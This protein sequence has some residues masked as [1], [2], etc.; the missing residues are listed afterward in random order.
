M[1]TKLIAGLCSA[2]LA[3]ACFSM[4]AFADEEFTT[5]EPTA[6][7][8]KLLG[9]TYYN[10]ES[11]WFS[12]TNSGVEYQFT[13]TATK[14]TVSGDANAVSATD[15][16]R[17]AVFA[18]G[19]RV[20]DTMLTYNPQTLTVN[21]EAGTHTIKLL[22]ISESA[23]G[24]IF[25]DDISVNGE[26]AITPTAAKKHSIE[27]IGDSITCGYGIDSKNENEHFSTFTEDGSRTY[28]YKAAQKLDAD[29]S[30]VSYSGFGVLSGYT[31]NGQINTTGLVSKYY[32][33]VGF[34]WGWANGH[35]ISEND[36]DFSAKPNDLVVVN[37]GTNDASYTK[38]NAEKIAD[39]TDAYVDF[40]KL[41]REKNP[42]SEI[43]CTLGIMGQDLYNA[44]EEAVNKYSEET[45]DIKVN[46][47]KFD[48]QDTADGLGGDWHPSEKTHEK[49]ANKLIDEINKLY[50]W[51]IDE[52]V[53]ISA[54]ENKLKPILED[55]N[56]NPI[57]PPDDSS[58]EDSSSEAVSSSDDTSS[59]DDESSSV[60][61]SAA[62]TSSAASS[63][64]SAS[65]SASTSSKATTTSSAASKAGDSNPTTGYAAAGAAFAVL[66]LGCI[67]VAKKQK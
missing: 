1:K 12:L 55:E 54:S 47:L 67:A 43:L 27:F 63:S 21:L 6:E 28:A 15:G 29:Y 14:I 32:D 41:I 30:M 65:S 13:G 40:I 19:E 3:A 20:K 36:W 59:K 2:A 57:L 33:K 24:S 56:G 53:D 44:I 18:D 8:V 45:G 64:V 7:N 42:D 11:L 17:I 66:A 62:D 50:G 52:S 26:G 25:I 34:S 10:G 31:G 51:E 4:A 23:N 58:G 60:N 5:Y 46:T 38:K 9:R 48:V 35:T 22:K 61:S 39:F 16:A 49:A 37:L